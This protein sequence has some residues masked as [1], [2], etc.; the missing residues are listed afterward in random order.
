MASEKQS[1][2]AEPLLPQATLATPPP[3]SRKLRWALLGAS[4]LA[5]TVYLAP[6]SLPLSHA[7]PSCLRAHHSHKKLGDLCPQQS[8]LYPQ[9]Y[10]DLWS[11][12]DS[13]YN[14]D[15]FKENTIKWLGGAVRVPTVVND[16]Q[17]PVGEDERWDVF[18]PFH[19]YLLEAFPLM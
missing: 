8:A 14:T 5:A 4:V 1:K 17:G 15:G 3:R 12:L 13:A 6:V 11:T 10:A 16:K 2:F 18:G 9:K 7:L 19:E